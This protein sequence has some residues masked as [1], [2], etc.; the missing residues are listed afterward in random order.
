MSEVHS[1]LPTVVFACSKTAQPL[2]V[3]S[4]L[5]TC[6]VTA[7]WRRRTKLRRGC[8]AL[9]SACTLTIEYRRRLRMRLL[10]RRRLL[11][12]QARAAAC[13]RRAAAIQRIKLA[14]AYPAHAH[15]LCLLPEAE[16]CFVCEQK[17]ISSATRCAGYSQCLT[18]C[19]MALSLVDTMEVTYSIL[20]R[21]NKKC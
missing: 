6:M 7:A 17:F 3:R 13:T 4:A 11:N 2:V 19:E 10:A 5:R 21:W 12:S 8:L 15:T 20:Q 1:K 16:P 14:L 18:A 9:N